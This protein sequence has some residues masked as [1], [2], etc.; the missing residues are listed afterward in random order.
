MVVE[1][2][3]YPCVII[4]DDQTIREMID[5]GSGKTG[6]S[7][8][9]RSDL[10]FNLIVYPS[11]VDKKDYKWNNKNIKEIWLDVQREMN[12]PEKVE[13]LVSDL[14]GPHL[15][16]DP[17]VRK[18]NLGIFER[19]NKMIFTLTNA[20]LNEYKGKA[21]FS[22]PRNPSRI[23]DGKWTILDPENG[24]IGSIEMKNGSLPITLGGFKTILL[25]SP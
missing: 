15:I 10:D 4:V 11:G 17:F 12:Q 20:T 6:K 19:D 1:H 2:G 23:Q 22:D 3:P 5:N 21:I 8:T 25:I 16:L 14:I 24:S 7:R 18:I 13:S 9:V